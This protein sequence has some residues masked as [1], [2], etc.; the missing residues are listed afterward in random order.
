M[1][2][3]QAEQPA[4]VWVQPH[5][6]AEPEV[7]VPA[8]PA[9]FTAAVAAA[10]AEIVATAA[11][12][13]MQTDMRV[14]AVAELGKV[15]AEPTGFPQLL[16]RLRTLPQMAAIMRPGQVAGL[17]VLTHQDRQERPAA[18]EAGH[19]TYIILTVSPAAPAGQ[20]QYITEL[21]QEA[22]AARAR[23]APPPQQQE[24]PV[25]Q[26]DYTAAA[27]AAEQLLREVVLLVTVAM[28]HKGP[29]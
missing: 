24:V 4:R 20:E 11:R 15:Q 10:R 12:A 26:E 27:A 2:R 3:R 23:L 14:Q 28:E 16:R 17:T 5:T 25:V 18:A 9:T 22:A 13:A 29:S 8:H 21:V 1:A 6:A 7:R 19:G